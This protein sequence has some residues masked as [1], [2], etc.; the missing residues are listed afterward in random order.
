MDYPI[1]GGCS[2]GAD[3]AGREDQGRGHEQPA[4]GEG[5]T[6]VRGEIPGLGVLVSRPGEGRGSELKREG[7]SLSLIHI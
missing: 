6:R 7:G 1:R 4:Q 5:L 3:E 2:Q